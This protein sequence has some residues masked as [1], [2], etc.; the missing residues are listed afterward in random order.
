M[1]V[2]DTDYAYS[3]S[4]IKALEKKLFDLQR[5][6]LLAETKHIDDV[7]KT[8]ADAGYPQHNDYT[9]MLNMSLDETYK[10]VKDI[11]PD[12]E[13]FNVFLVKNDYHNLKVLIKA[14][15]LGINPDSLLVSGGLIRV[16]ELK[17]SFTNRKLGSMPQ[18]MQRAA[19]KALE[20]FSVS[21]NPQA[22]EIILDL[23]MYEQMVKMANETENSYIIGYVKKQIDL[24]NIKTLFRMKLQN[25]TEA[26]AKDTFIPNG[27]ISVDAFVR[28]MKT[29]PEE[30]MA[31]IGKTGYGYIVEDGFDMIKLEQKCNLDNFAYI[32]KGRGMYFGPEPLIAYMLSKEEEIK[33]LRIIISGKLGGVSEKIITERLNASYV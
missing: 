9:R 4:K 6:V 12:P 31:A 2:A 19:K 16:E 30:T 28:L 1:K 11:S 27:S 7:Y 15:F 22:A 3:Q 18:T 14:E 8:L 20:T 23:A 32:K 33:Q 24:T 17:S 21:N 13:I 25:K 29:S 10:L 26:F 5:L